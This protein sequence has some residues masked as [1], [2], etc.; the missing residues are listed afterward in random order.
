MQIVWKGQACFY[1]TIVRG[2]QDQVKVLIDP[3]EDSLGLKLPAQEADIVLVTHGHSDHNHV[4][5]AKGDAESQSWGDTFNGTT[6]TVMSVENK[7]DSSD[8]L[9]FVI[10]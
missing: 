2:K 8:K 6:F 5:I 9:D 10:S 3:F 7:D 4:K 1:I